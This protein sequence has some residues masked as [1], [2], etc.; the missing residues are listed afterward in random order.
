[1]ECPRIGLRGGAILP[2]RPAVVSR[3]YL[4]SLH[5][6]ERELLG[7]IQPA[8]LAGRY[9]HA[10]MLL[11]CL[12]NISMAHT[13]AWLGEEQWQQA[14]ATIDDASTGLGRLGHELV[15]RLLGG[16]PSVYLP[17]PTAERD[18]FALALRVP[19]PRV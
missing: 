4:R 8:M 13:L 12:T 15:R 9:A 17:L 7:E 3:G 14:K 19:H 16:W 5:T 11:E 6:I 1:M 10:A 18:R 2:D